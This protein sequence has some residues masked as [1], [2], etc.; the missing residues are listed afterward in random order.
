MTR[1]QFEQLVL[2]DPDRPW[3]TI[4]GQ[5]REKPAMSFAHNRGSMELGFLLNSQLDRSRYLVSIN[6]VP[7]HRGHDG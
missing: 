1:E 5:L 4:R 7:A 3:K 6:L 2:D